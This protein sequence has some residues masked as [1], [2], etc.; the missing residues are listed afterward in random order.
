MS[1][2]KEKNPQS[3]ARY[4]GWI[5]DESS[6]A[7]IQELE[8]RIKE[9]VSRQKFYQEAEKKRKDLDVLDLLASLEIRFSDSK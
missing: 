8:K 6:G 9:R 2:N 1:F 5:G 4:E 7:P 3:S